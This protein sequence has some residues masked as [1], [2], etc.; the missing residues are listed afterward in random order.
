MLKNVNKISI[1]V[2]ENKNRFY[3]YFKTNK[4]YN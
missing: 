4:L 3:K 1:L 2:F